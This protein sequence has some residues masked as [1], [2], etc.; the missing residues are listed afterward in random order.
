[1]RVRLQHFYP[2]SC[3]RRRT[4]DLNPSSS[5]PGAKGV[6]EKPPILPRVRVVQTKNWFNKRNC[7]LFFFKAFYMKWFKETFP[8][9]HKHRGQW[10][11]FSSPGS[12][13]WGMGGKLHVVE[14]VPSLIFLAFH[15]SGS[16]DLPKPLFCQERAE[17]GEEGTDFFFLLNWLKFLIKIFIL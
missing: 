13:C 12:V 5:S 9:L 6:E 16:W 3:C 4:G 14:K 15:S 7:G 17:V 8:W 11:D 10:E 2:Y 1:M